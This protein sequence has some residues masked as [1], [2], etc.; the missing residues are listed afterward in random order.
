[1]RKIELH[2]GFFW[3][4]D[5]CGR[6]HFERALVPTL[7]PDEIEYI[8]VTHNIEGPHVMIISPAYV[9]CKDCNTTFKTEN[10]TL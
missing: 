10:Q 4:C 1:M 3:D 6:E 2:N 7:N 8:K 9:T 5:E